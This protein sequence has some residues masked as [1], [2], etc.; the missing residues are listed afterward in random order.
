MRLSQFVFS[1][2]LAAF[3]WSDDA[4]ADPI[5]DSTYRVQGS[6]IGNDQVGTDVECGAVPHA[7]SAVIY[8][9]AYPSPPIVNV[10]GVQQDGHKILASFIVPSGGCRF[11]GMRFDPS[12]IPDW[13]KPPHRGD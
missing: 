11:P 9:T 2:F 13:A 6:W 8:A 3:I 1:V 12:Q 4:V 5:Q 7:S 10:Y